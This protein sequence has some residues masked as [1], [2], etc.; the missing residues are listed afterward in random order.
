[1]SNPISLRTY[2][3][4]LLKSISN[5]VE[6]SDGCGDDIFETKEEV[7]EK[8]IDNLD[9]KEEKVEAEPEA[10]SE[11]VRV[12]KHVKLV[13]GKVSWLLKS[14]SEKYDNFYSEKEEVIPQLLCDGPIP[15]SEWHKELKNSS[16][17]TT[18][19]ELYDLQEI[20]ARMKEVKGLR[21]RM[22]EMAIRC[23][24]QYF[25]WERTI[26]LF[27]GLL[28]RI[29]PNLKPAQGREGFIYEHMRDMEFYFYKLK[30]FHKAVDYVSKT[31][32]LVF[33][34]LSRQ[35]TIALQNREPIERYARTDKTNQSLNVNQSTY[36]EKTVDEDE[37]KDFDKLPD[38]DKSGSE[39]S[40]TGKEVDWETM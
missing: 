18:T 32:E 38:S 2:C 26:D 19:L 12:I 6:E 7:E 1:M 24:M 31:L 21:D 25:L 8:K 33:E 29:E 13:D 23:N 34:A 4:V 11:D 14:P 9:K 22:Q 40:K 30:G 16:V 39:S 20:H 10:E 36:L 35:V 28:C 27:H 37:F 17:D 5:A 15:F 3:N